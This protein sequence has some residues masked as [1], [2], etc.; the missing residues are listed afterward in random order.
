M[1]H[2]WLIYSIVALWLPM[3][4]VPMAQTSRKP[5][6]ASVSVSFDDPP[7]NMKTGDEATTTLVFRAL[8]DTQRLEVFLDPD[9]GLEMVSTATEAVFTNL[10]AQE[11]RQLA[12]KV[13][14]TA[15]KGSS[16]NV[17]FS[18]VSGSADDTQEGFGSTVIDYG[19]PRP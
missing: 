18:T 6:S 12:V 13:K 16:L 14:L 7:P 17:S 5:I 19:D 10:K 3:V 15:P 1:K 8:A 4:A 9:D 11:T 2:R